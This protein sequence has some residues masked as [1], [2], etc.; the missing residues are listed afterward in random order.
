MYELANEEVVTMAGSII[1]EDHQHLSE[2]TITYLFRE[3]SWKRGDGRTILGRASK[4]NEIDKI[5]SNRREDFI[6]ILVKPRWDGMSDE[7][8]RCLLDH[9]LCH[10]GVQVTNSGQRKWILRS[11]PIEE[12][13][14][15]LARFAFRREQMG[16]LIQN[17]PSPIVSRPTGTRR[18][19]PVEVED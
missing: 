1:E 4:R 12:F 2:A 14:E 19:R 15:N 6:I 11:H 13:P 18:L 17:P 10:A 7:E 3:R 9:E 8:R 5:L 16:S